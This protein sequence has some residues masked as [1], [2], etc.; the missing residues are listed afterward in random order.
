MMNI[1]TIGAGSLQPKNGIWFA[2]F[3]NTE[4]RKYIWR[5]TKIKIPNVNKKTKTYKDAYREAYDLIPVIREGL[6]KNKKIEIFQQE[7]QEPILTVCELIQDW[8]ATNAKKEVRKSTYSIYEMYAKKRIYPFFNT[9]YPNLDAEDVT[10]EIMQ[11]FARSM[12]DEG[13]KTSSIR[14]YLVPVRDAFAFG[15]DEEIIKKNPIVDYRYIP[16]RLTL[17]EKQAEKKTKRRAYT[18]DE[19]KAMMAAIE[20]E[21]YAPATIPV[22]LS[23]RIGLRREE[24]LGLCYSHIDFEKKVVRVCNTVTNVVKIIEEE[25]TKSVAGGRTVP[26]DNW[27]L[28]YLKNLRAVQALNKE[29]LGSEYKVSDYVYVRADG[30]RYYPDTCDKQLKKFL[31]RNNL[32]KICLHELRH[33][34]CTMLIASGKDL[35]TV[36]AIM[37]HEDSRMTVELYAHTVEEKI[38]SA[39]DAVEF[40]LAS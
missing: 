8:L 18:K 11:E 30:G 29:N 3:Y 39:A 9:R 14:K 38:I 26:I 2:V 5:T 31:K 37:G 4:T 33:T 32:N 21:N 15:I 34:F 13:L 28:N 35:K 36:Q 1:D 19:I 7:E 23:L 16:K 20:K 17:E 24:I 40:F 27:T 6:V 12:K 25:N 10:H 22:V